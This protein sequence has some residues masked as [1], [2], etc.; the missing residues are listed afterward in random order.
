MSRI[1]T[2]A[3]ALA[4]IAGS[5]H[6][7]PVTTTF[8][9]DNHYAVYSRTIGGFTFQGG[10][11]LGPEGSSGGYNWSV[12]ETY[13]FDADDY[14]YIAA[15]SD[16]SVAQGLIGQVVTA[17]E[18]ILSGDGRWEVYSTGDDRGDWSPYPTV[19]EMASYVSTADSGDL[20]EV[21]HVG[22]ANGIAPWNSIATVSGDSRWMWRGTTE[23]DP[24]Q[25][26][27][28]HG[29]M[30]IFRIPVAIPAPGPLALAGLGGLL[31]SKRRR[32]N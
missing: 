28:N 27:A 29:E 15:W 7:G 1:V 19:G 22:G 8:T 17:S 30:L 11:E 31:L 25:G 20:W 24:L 23:G 12:A 26:G 32:S 14:L 10:N 5:A 4:V 18:T 3:A 9:A 16:N 6:A 2:I 13:T 21:P